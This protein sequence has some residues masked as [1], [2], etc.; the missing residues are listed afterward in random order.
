MRRRRNRQNPRRQ[1]TPTR[2]VPMAKED[3]LVKILGCFTSC[4]HVCPGHEF[5]KKQ[6][7]EDFAA[8]VSA[9]LGIIS[10]SDEKA[11]ITKVS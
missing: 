4:Y 10:K 7:T 9:V 5:I 11:S 6:A 2:H 3:A 8:S 1:R